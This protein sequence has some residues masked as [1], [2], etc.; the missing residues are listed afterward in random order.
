[1]KK[2]YFIISA[3]LLGVSAAFAVEDM[4]FVTTL[5][6]PLAVFDK[7]ETSSAAE[8]AKAKKATIGVTN[9]S[10]S[11]NTTLR[12]NSKNARMQ[13]L[14][15]N[16]N[17]NFGGNVSEWKTPKISVSGGGSLTGK[18]LKATAFNFTGGG[19]NTI[20]ANNN[21]QVTSNIAAASAT[22][23]NTLNIANKD[24]YQT[25]ENVPTGGTATKW[26]SLTA[27]T[28][29]TQK[30]YTNIL[31]YGDNAHGP[32]SGNASSGKWTLKSTA[33]YG[34]C[35]AGDSP[36]GGDSCASV[37]GKSGASIAN[38]TCAGSLCGVSCLYTPCQYSN[39]NYIYVQYTYTCQC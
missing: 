4:R 14:Q 20:T 16:N 35:V 17:T 10:G 38:T 13:T 3:L 2:H 12:L 6:A 19:V 8:P 32:R 30:T 26:A 25:S 11:F 21:I 5:S 33:Q 28:S 31:Y 36:L 7:V 23:T 15:L 1:M 18:Q 24:W 29:D 22:A 39:P 34:N 27:G 9:N 37:A